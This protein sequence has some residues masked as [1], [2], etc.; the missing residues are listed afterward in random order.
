[1]YIKY[2]AS[3]D[4]TPPR[5]TNILVTFDDDTH[6]SWYPI[7]SEGIVNVESIISVETIICILL[8]EY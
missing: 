2:E 1:M 5:K 3:L 8:F 6:T 4:H 7:S